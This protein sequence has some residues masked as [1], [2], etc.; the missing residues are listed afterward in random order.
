MPGLNEA[1]LNAGLAQRTNAHPNG[2][3][4][5]RADSEEAR[6]KSE[7]LKR[8]FEA[9]DA[10]CEAWYAEDYGSAQELREAFRMAET[11]KV[12]RELMRE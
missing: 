1:E 10:A 4:E 11:W 6:R 2:W 3:V 9:M 12:I 5:D 7:R 8:L